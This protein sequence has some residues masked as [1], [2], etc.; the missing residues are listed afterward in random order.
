[1]IDSF[2][3]LRDKIEES[4]CRADHGPLDRDYALLTLHRLSDVKHSEKFSSVIEALE[5]VAGDISL[6]LVAHPRTMK[7]LARFDLKDR[8]T[9]IDSV[10]L[11]T[12]LP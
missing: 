2:E 6:V 9:N 1:M 10:D 11:L 3:L 12:P 5:S 8:L 4:T 7:N